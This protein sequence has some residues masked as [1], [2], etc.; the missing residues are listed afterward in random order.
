MSPSSEI[1]RGKFRFECTTFLCQAGQSLET[2]GNI[3]FPPVSLAEPSHIRFKDFSG[4]FH[5]SFKTIVIKK[6]F[7]CFAF[8]LKS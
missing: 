5:A 2:I 4:I 7:N 3:G 6:S 1:L 8:Y